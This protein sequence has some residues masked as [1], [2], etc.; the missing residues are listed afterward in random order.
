MWVVRAARLAGEGLAHHSSAASSPL[1][2]THRGLLLTAACRSALL[3]TRAPHALRTTPYSLRTARL[4]GEELPHAVRGHDHHRVLL[5][6][7]VVRHLPCR[8]AEA[9]QERR[10]LEPQRQ[11]GAGAD[12][13]LTHAAGRYCY[14]RL[15]S[16][17]SS[18]LS[19]GDGPI[20]DR[21]HPATGP[22]H[23]VACTRVRVRVHVHAPRR[24]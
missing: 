12:Q 20:G 24:G 21:R 23:H 13:C 4:A 19:F 16:G 9:A 17:L 11:S 6:D 10:A 8:E 2:T 1:P 3:R 15:S 5:G 7:R 22:A 18:G 14:R